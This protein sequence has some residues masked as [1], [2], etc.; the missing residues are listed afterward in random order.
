MDQHGVGE[1]S[2]EPRVHF[3]EDGTFASETPLE[4]PRTR[5]ATL[6][7]RD[8]NRVLR[9]LVHTLPIDAAVEE[10]HVEL[11]MVGDEYVSGSILFEGD[12]PADC[13]VK[14][15]V[16][17]SVPA[18]SLDFAKARSGTHATGIV[19]RT[20]DGKRVAELTEA[21]GTTPAPDG[22]F[23]IPIPGHGTATLELRARGHPV[24]VLELGLLRGSR[25]AVRIYLPPS[26]P[27]RP[28]QLTA[29][30]IDLRQGAGSW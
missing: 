4:V 18:D 1:R 22:S 10:L 13:D 15:T 24:R 9:P 5:G 20:V 28:L 11:E 17:S 25:D 26:G 23:R 30:E 14:L 8:H 7:L 16:T 29:G 21:S 6:V 27:R 19:I 12:L 3:G 2:R